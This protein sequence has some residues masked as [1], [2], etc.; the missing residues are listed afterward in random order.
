M[1]WTMS[2]P[3]RRVRNGWE[4]DSLRRYTRTHLHAPS[5]IHTCTR[6]HARMLVKLTHT[7]VLHCALRV[8][9]LHLPPVDPK[10]PAALAAQIS[11]EWSAAPSAAV[12]FVLHHRNPSSSTAAAAARGT[13]QETPSR[14]SLFIWLQIPPS[15]I[16]KTTWKAFHVS[17]KNENEVIRANMKLVGH[18]M[19]QLL[20]LSF[21]SVNS[22]SSFSSP[23]DSAV[24][25]RWEPLFFAINI[26]LWFICLPSSC[27]DLL[28]YLRMWSG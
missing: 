16:V 17:K 2:P 22:M 21:P 15:Y 24:G 13:C 11:T 9:S 20:L 14:R 23:A 18:S 3:S 4:Y 8:H 26:S 25:K 28:W 27:K 5:H 6:T 19:I 12:F 7:S 1:R 10:L